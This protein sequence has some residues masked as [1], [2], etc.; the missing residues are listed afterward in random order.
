MADRP[1]PAAWSTIGSNAARRARATPSG[2]V[3]PTSSTPARR[4][5][6]TAGDAVMHPLLG[7]RSALRARASHWSALI[8]GRDQGARRVRAPARLGH[9]HDLVRAQGHLGHA[10]RDRAQP[11]RA[12]GDVADPGGRDQAVLQGGPAPRARRPLRLQAGA[13]PVARAGVPGVR[14]RPRRRRRDHRRTTASSCRSPTRRS[15]SSSCWPCRRIVGLRGDAGGLVVGVEVPAARLGA[16]L[17]AD[18]LLR[19]GAGH[20]DRDGGAHRPGRCGRAGSSAR[21]Q[22]GRSGKWNLSGSAS[23][24]SSSS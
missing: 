15:G 23:S 20:D 14:H 2:S 24:R 4:H 17:G 22:P 6:R 21:H 19:G 5:R 11:G 8:V 10:G 7:G 18:D 3:R 13:V 1:C 16:G 9:A 12:V